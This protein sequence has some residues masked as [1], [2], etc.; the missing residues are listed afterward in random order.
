[1]YFFRIG[2]FVERI[3]NKHE[4]WSLS[5]VRNAMEGCFKKKFDL[6][7]NGAICHIWSLTQ[8]WQE[9]RLILRKM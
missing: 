7:W 4:R 8:N 6:A 3:D 9:G 5:I 2:A 1:L